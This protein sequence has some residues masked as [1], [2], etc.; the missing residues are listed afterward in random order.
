[1]TGEGVTRR[2]KMGAGPAIPAAERLGHTC[3]YLSHSVSPGRRVRAAS[4]TPGSR[5]PGASLSHSEV[6]RG[7][8]Q[9][10]RAMKNPNVSGPVRKATPTSSAIEANTFY[11]T[12]VKT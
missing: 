8:K 11:V 10:S 2:A 5:N 1:M 12:R 3:R 4:R 6:T 9:W 7:T